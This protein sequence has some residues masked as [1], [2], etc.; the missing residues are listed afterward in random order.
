MIY[1]YAIITLY[2][3]IICLPTTKQV[4]TE[5]VKTEQVK[6][7]IL[8]FSQKSYIAVFPKWG[9]PKIKHT[10]NLTCTRIYF[11]CNWFSK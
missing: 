1:P 7:P 9:F 5:Q 3:K 2:N 6:N 11:L 4:N 10:V 8:R